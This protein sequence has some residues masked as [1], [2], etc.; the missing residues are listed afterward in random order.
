M[1]CLS[2]LGAIVIRT[3]PAKPVTLRV[4][5][6]SGNAALFLFRVD[7]LLD[8]QDLTVHCIGRVGDAYKVGPAGGT[9]EVLLPQETDPNGWDEL[10]TVDS[11]VARAAYWRRRNKSAPKMT[12]TERVA[13][14]AM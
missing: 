3:G 6:D 2:A 14:R 8:G 13:L 10:F 12:P 4:I 9:G 11:G 5:S 7:L 1:S